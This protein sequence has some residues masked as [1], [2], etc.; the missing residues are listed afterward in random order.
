MT[1]IRRKYTREDYYEAACHYM[2]TG[3]QKATAKALNIP[4]KTLNHWVKNN[5]DFAAMYQKAANDNM[6]QYDAKVS[7]LIDKSLRV[8]ESKL[9]YPDDISAK[10]AALIHNMLYDKRQLARNMPTAI[11]KKDNNDLLRLADAFKQVARG[12]AEKAIQGEV[13]DGIVEPE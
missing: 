6:K 12:N 1:G 9:Q 2:V 5:E 13:V 4:Q 10:D 7:S 11:S 3:S 8:L